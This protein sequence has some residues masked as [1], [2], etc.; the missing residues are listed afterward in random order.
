[1]A[2]FSSWVHGNAVKLQYPGGAGLE[3]TDHSRMD[4]VGGHAFTDITGLPQGPGT[5]FV[6]N[7]DDNNWLHIVIPTPVL[8]GGFL[9]PNRAKVTKVFVLFSAEQFRRS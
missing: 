9:D 8:I 2:N 7:G 4:Q 5:E 3:F 6:G 1:M